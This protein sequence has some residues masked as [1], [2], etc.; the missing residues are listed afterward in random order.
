MKYRKKPVVI[1]AI[2]F[3][4]TPCGALVVFDLFD[5]PGGKFHPDLADLNR[6]H[7]NIPTLKGVMS[8]LKG[9]F[10][11]KG[12]KGEFYPCKPDIF[13]ATYEAVDDNG[14]SIPLCEGCRAPATGQDSEGVPLCDECAKAN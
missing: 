11:I 12:V 5:I 10:V 9:D 2:Q 4:G 3:D 8:A 13:A 6:G 14:E 1:D 7:L